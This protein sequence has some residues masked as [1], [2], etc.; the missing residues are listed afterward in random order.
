VIDELAT[1][2]GLPPDTE[3]GTLDR[4]VVLRAWEINTAAR[5]LLERDTLQ[6]QESRAAGSPG[7]R[8]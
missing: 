3:P 6:R 8:R 2:L 4:W 5:R 7:P 1:E